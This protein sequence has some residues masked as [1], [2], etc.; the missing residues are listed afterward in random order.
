MQITNY[1]DEK[2]WGLPA[3]IT[4]HLEEHVYNQILHSTEIQILFRIL[5]IL[6]NKCKKRETKL[7]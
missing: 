3:K 1:V 6:T 4:Q 7:N 2:S 5:F